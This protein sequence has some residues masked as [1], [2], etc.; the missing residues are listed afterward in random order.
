MA[1]PMLSCRLLLRPGCGLAAAATT[2]QRVEGVTPGAG[3]AI[4]AN[5]VMQMVDPWQYGVQDTDLSV[6]A[7][8]GSQRAA[9]GRRR[10]QRR[11]CR[12]R[13]STTEQLTDHRPWQPTPNPA[14][15]CWFRRTRRSRRTRARP[16][17]RR[18]SSSWSPSRRTSPSCAAKSRKPIAAPSSSTWMPRKLEEIEALQR[19]TRRL[20][21]KAP[22]VVVTPGIQCRRRAHPRAAAG[23]RLPGQAADHRGS[24]PL[25]HPRPAGAGPRGE[26]G[27]ADLYLH[28]RRRRRRHHDA[29]P[30][31]GLPAAQFGDARRLDLRRRPQFPAGRLRRISR[32][33]A[34]LR[35]CR[36]R[37]PAG[38]PR[39]AVARRDAVQACER[40]VRARR[41]DP[42]VGDALLQ[43]RS[44]GAHARPRL[45]LFRQCRDRHAAHLVPVDRDR[46]ARLQ[47]ALHRRRDDGAVPA[48]HAAADPGDLR[49][50]R[51][52]S[53]AQRHRQPLRAARPSKTA[54]SR[55]T[56]KK[57]SAT[58]SPAASPTTTGWCARRSTAA[59]RCRR[60]TPTPMSSTT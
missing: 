56:S 34:A 47:Q 28:P 27:I 23:R 29:R 3:D 22:I 59:C 54:S 39:P 42:A 48:P 55:P 37:E 13:P 20:E 53:E 32:P 14:R 49:D 46:A 43:H 15:S 45:G 25:L 1:R 17:P 60:S 36:D 40:A 51:Q 8:R 38:A 26:H 35:H 10:S 12:Q 6:P 58:I 30:A 57:S 41:T 11:R 50:G 52:G 9:E 31:D 19:I 16:S 7:D 4:A 44:R 2:Y 24:R 33:R 21:G 5:T 18:T